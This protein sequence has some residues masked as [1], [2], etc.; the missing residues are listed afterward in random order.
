RT[1]YAEVDGTPVL[2]VAPSLTLAI[3]LVD[4]SDRAAADQEAELRRLAAADGQQPFDLA[5]GP[6]LRATLVRRGAE[7]HVLLL[8]FC[9]VAFDGWSA[10]VLLGELAALYPAFAGGAPSPLPELPVQYGD[11]AAWQRALV[12]SPALDD[13]VAYWRQQFGDAVPAARLPTA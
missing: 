2:R 5:H 4:L 13:Q 11:Y 12:A 1:T 6:V 10:G 8:T 3:P 7:D 9:H